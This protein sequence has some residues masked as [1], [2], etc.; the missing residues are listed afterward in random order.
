VRSC[1]PAQRNQGLAELPTRA[2]CY[3]VEQDLRGLRR[4]IACRQQV[5]FRPTVLSCGSMSRQSRPQKALP[6]TRQFHPEN[7]V[8]TRCTHSPDRR[9]WLAGDAAPATC[10]AT[11][12]S[13]TSLCGLP[14]LPFSSYCRS[15]ILN[16][17]SQTLYV[18][19]PNTSK[20]ILRGAP[21]LEPSAARKARRTPSL[22]P[23]EQSIVSS[24]TEV[25][26]PP[27]VTRHPHTLPLWIALLLSDIVFR[28]AAG[29]TLGCTFGRS[30]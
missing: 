29:R 13:E 21:S 26:R 6:G 16:D 4:R 25:A 10:I 9:R 2:G 27:H 28:A 19:C 3:P 15:C 22:G 20:P 18:R 23:E 12:K 11:A 24:L 7:P 1:R 8:Q 17:S 5:H 30:A 14:A